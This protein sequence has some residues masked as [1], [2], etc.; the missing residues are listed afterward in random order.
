MIAEQARTYANLTSSWRLMAW[1]Q[2][3]KDDGKKIN[4]LRAPD[5]EKMQVPGLIDLL[6]D[7]PEEFT[8]TEPYTGA[9]YQLAEAT[10]FSDERKVPVGGRHKRT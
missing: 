7:L 8:F 10:D 2:P 1:V 4:L 5:G 6:A 9:K 3:S